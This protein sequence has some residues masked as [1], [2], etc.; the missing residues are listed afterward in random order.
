M[1]QFSTETAPLADEL[2]QEILATRSVLGLPCPCGDHERRPSPGGGHHLVLT[3]T[4]DSISSVDKALETADVA[5]DITDAIGSGIDTSM[6]TADECAQNN[7]Q[8]NERMRDIPENLMES[9]ICFKDILHSDFDEDAILPYMGLFNDKNGSSSN[10]HV[11]KICQLLELD[12]L[13]LEGSTKLGQTY[14]QCVQSV[15]YNQCVSFTRSCLLPKVMESCQNLPQNFTNLVQS[16]LRK[17]QSSTMDGLYQAMFQHEQFES[18]QADL[19]VKTMKDEPILVKHQ[20]LCQITSLQTPWT[21][22]HIVVLENLIK[23]KVK[24]EIDNQLVHNMCRLMEV[25]SHEMKNNLKF[26]KLVLEVISKYGKQ[27]S[28]DGIDLLN[29]AMVPH[30]TFMKKSVDAALKKLIQ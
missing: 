25:S 26:G 3:A 6:G 22:A 27:L 13:P 1:H 9:C 15:R 19:V 12:K 23:T 4:M 11:E 10:D 2:C 21:K 28:S 14:L 16:F 20:L 7:E 8:R 17:H 5:M 29:S 30:T 18:P 24:I